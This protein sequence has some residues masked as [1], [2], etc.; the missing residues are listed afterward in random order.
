MK[1]IPIPAQWIDLRQTPDLTD[2]QALR[3]GSNSS[4]QIIIIG[5]ATVQTAR[6]IQFQKKELKGVVD[7]RAIRA[8]NGQKVASSYQTATITENESL[9]GNQEV[10][11]LLATL[12]GKDLSGQLMEIW[13]KIAEHPTEVALVVKGTRDLPI[14]VQFQK[15]LE[16]IPDVSAV[17]LTELAPDQTRLRVD[18]KGDTRALARAIA[19]SD[20]EGFSITISEIKTNMIQV[21]LIPN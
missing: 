1:D 13:P 4:A 14:S 18:Y 19:D 7:L 9:T 17:L 12:A 6:F 20:Y 11:S 21:Q 16:I 8:D 3:L 2:K 5:S 10:L 15:S